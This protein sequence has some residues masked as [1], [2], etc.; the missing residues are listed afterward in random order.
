[1]FKQRLNQLCGL[2]LLVFAVAHT[3]TN[4]LEETLTAAIT[5][6]EAA[7]NLPQGESLIAATFSPVDNSSYAY[8]TQSAAANNLILTVHTN[9]LT[10]THTW[11]NMPGANE[12]R[13]MF[14]Q[15]QPDGKQLLI[16]HNPA[17]TNFLSLVS[18]EPNNTLSVDNAVM[19]QN[20]VHFI[21]TKDRLM[22]TYQDRQTS[23]WH[24]R[25]LF[26]VKVGTRQ[27]TR[28]AQHTFTHDPAL[29]RVVPAS[30]TSP[31]RSHS[32]RLLIVVKSTDIT[33][34]S[35]AP[36]R[37]TQ[38]ALPLNL[39]VVAEAKPATTGE[40]FGILINPALHP[41]TSKG[42]FAVAM[43]R[44]GNPVGRGLWQASI[45]NATR[46]S[47]TRRAESAADPLAPGMMLT[48]EFSGPA[49][50]EG[51]LEEAAGEIKFLAINEDNEFVQLAVNGL[52]IENLN[53]T[54]VACFQMQTEDRKAY[55]FT[56]VNK[57]A[58][59]NHTKIWSSKND[60]VDILLQE[61]NS[62][63]FG[64]K[65]NIG[66]IGR[67]TET[68]N[69]ITFKQASGSNQIFKETLLI[70]KEGILTEDDFEL[71]VGILLTNDGNLP[72][73]EFPNIYRR[74]NRLFRDYKHQNPGKVLPTGMLPLWVAQDPAVR[75][76]YRPHQEQQDQN[77]AGQAIRDISVA[78]DT[79]PFFISLEALNGL[80]PAGVNT[81]QN[82]ETRVQFTRADV[83]TLDGSFTYWSNKQ[84][85]GRP[86]N[87]DDFYQ[88]A[89]G[90]CPVL[91]EPFTIEHAEAKRFI[92]LRSPHLT[93]QQ[94]DAFLNQFANQNV[95]AVT[96]FL[97]AAEQLPQPVVN[98]A[99]P[100][101][102]LTLQE[103]AFR[104]ISTAQDDRPHFINEQTL[105]RLLPAGVNQAQ[106]PVTHRAFTRDDVKKFDQSYIYWAQKDSRPASIHQFLQQA[107]TDGFTIERRSAERFL[108]V[109]KAFLNEER[110]AEFFNQFNSQ[111]YI[112][113][114]RFLQAAEQIQQPIMPDPNQNAAPA[115]EEELA[116]REI[117]DIASEN[118]TYD[119]GPAEQNP[120]SDTQPY[121]ISKATLDGLLRE[122]SWRGL[123]NPFTNGRFSRRDIKNF[124]QSFNFWKNKQINNRPFTLEI[125]LEKANDENGDPITME[126]FTIG[127]PAATAYLHARG[128]SQQRIDTIFNRF[129]GQDYIDLKEF[130]QAAS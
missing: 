70:D 56:T 49:V 66:L 39:A 125:F 22:W 59:Q 124:A 88:R 79:Q 108:H 100:A 23:A 129:P 128:I 113:L 29:L 82:P 32:L 120:P 26:S 67:G 69:F 68:P 44:G 35:V 18:I 27:I 4:A 97:Q 25:V 16:V 92:S 57:G 77:P 38:G 95:I 84:V 14:S 104:D 5:Q 112:P 28:A 123:K 114:A 9:G 122:G 73:N 107:K 52:N 41:I 121:F 48:S 11:N 74:L 50:I 47:F 51:L 96:T 7:F 40:Q 86:Y 20:D 37:P 118:P 60:A 8:L 24:A 13:V 12:C 15:F 30:V 103:Q 6:E 89:R 64:L 109:T 106:N 80:L 36:G 58:V 117:I 85:G 61:N 3:V 111:M 65:P 55:I 53:N 72:R 45:D 102:H 1:M 54:Q 110:I 115:T 43:Q 62:T 10:L 19:Q 87:M 116:G 101:V 81:A 46:V 126:P 78:T 90:N 2:L 21:H 119:R 98:P 34:Y 94:I 75:E 17:A 71:K 31:D 42:L 63:W 91:M 127:R 93:Q 130:L 99:Q 105:A 33:A 83:K 76:A